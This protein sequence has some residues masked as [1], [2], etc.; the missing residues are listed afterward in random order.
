MRSS[1]LRMSAWPALSGWLDRHVIGLA[2]GACMLLA[3]LGIVAITA[4]AR[5]DGVPGWW[6]QVDTVVRSDPKV[7]QQAEHLENAITTQLTM[8]R[9]PRDPRWAA[10][11][12]PDQANAWLEV[13]LI[14]TIRTHMGKEA[15]PSEI[16]RIRIGIDDDQLVLGA[17]MAHASGSSIM[18]AMIGIE[19]D[20]H[21]DLWANLSSV[22]VGT[23]P[24]PTRVLTIIGSSGKSSSR[25]RIG[26]GRLDLGDGRVAQL[27]A[28][29]ISGGRLEMV[30][31]T[32]ADDQ[33]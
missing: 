13:R 14:D 15:W 9:D 8:V 29:R 27:V 20:E 18:W 17:R 21:G 23:T 32:R 5:L 22:H 7:I 2:I 33:S 3:V 11:I 24:M 30:M 12:N 10:A 16:E 19:L 1:K 4:V 26:P 6:L 31:E 28:L 25:I